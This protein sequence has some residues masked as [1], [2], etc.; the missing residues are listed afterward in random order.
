MK[1]IVLDEDKKSCKKVYNIPEAKLN[2]T[3]KEKI[4]ELKVRNCHICGVIH[5]NIVCNNC[6]KNVCSL[7]RIKVGDNYICDHCN[8]TMI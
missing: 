6:K 1:V 4:R 7:H 2:K 8:K 3:A 5:S